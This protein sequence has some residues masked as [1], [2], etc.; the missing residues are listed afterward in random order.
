MRQQQQQRGC[1]S[2]SKA[3]KRAAAD[4][5]YV[6]LQLLAG[7]AGVPLTRVALSSTQSSCA[8]QPTICEGRGKQLLKHGHQEY[9]SAHEFSARHT[10]APC[11]CAATKSQPCLICTPPATRGPKMTNKSYNRLTHPQL[12]LPHNNRRHST[13]QP[14][15]ATHTTLLHQHSAALL[16]G[17]CWWAGHCTGCVAAVVL[18]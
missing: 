2:A 1:S 17:I 12:T 15:H 10:T 7:S 5:R 16:A 8:W 9:P 13:R 3:H 18:Q 11:G 4:R 6:Q 14:N